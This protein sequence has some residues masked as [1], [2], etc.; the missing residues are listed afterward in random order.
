VRFGGRR[1]DSYSTNGLGFLMATSGNLEHTAVVGLAWGDEGKGKIV[2]LLCA[3]FDVVV[4][5]N[6]GANAGHTVCVGGDTFA[7]HLLPVGLLREQV[8]GVI[9]QG[10]VV[11][12]SALV[13][14]LDE[15]A[16]R[17]LNV[18]DRL[19]ISDR[20]HLVMAYHKIEDRLREGGGAAQR[21]GTTARGIGP[22]YA[23]KMLRSPALRMADLLDLPSVEA[24]V[25]KTVDGKRSIFQ[26]RYGDDGGINFGDVWADLRTA[27]DRLGP[28]IGD[29]ST[30]L[31]D[32]AEAGERLFFEGANGMLLDVDQ[33]TYPYVTSSNTGPQGIAAGAGVPPNLVGRCVGVT[34]AYTTRVGEG[35]FPTELADETGDRIRE[36]G[37]EY[38]TTTGRPRRCGWLDAFAIRASVRTGGV[39]EIALAHLDT[40]SG[41]EKVGMCTGYRLK[42][43]P[44]AALPASA[45]DLSRVDVQVE[46]LPG[47]TGDLRNCGDFAE[48][49]EAARAFVTR[50][51]SFAGAPVTI[52]SVGPDRNHTILRNPIR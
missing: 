35:P 23:D 41:F 27:A 38:G 8:T 10:V 39:S 18:A 45:G 21:I 6:G 29:A 34:K 48:L 17:G 42:G 13:T 52:I 32:R 28:M 19:L 40:L 16:R 49:P 9:G 51:E 33:G 14:E 4:R 47:W 36:A 15:L 2:D 11:D 20:A 43:Q 30:Q 3:D 25:R 31:L 37:N 46:M 7:L 5:F 26:A 50:L 24:R 44:L 12:P 1:V 22:A